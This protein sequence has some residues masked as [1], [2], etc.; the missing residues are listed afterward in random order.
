MQNLLAQEHPLSITTQ[1]AVRRVGAIV[2]MLADDI[3]HAISIAETMEAANRIVPP[4]LAGRDIEGADAYRVI[5]HSLAQKLALDVARIFDASGGRELDIQDKASIPVLIHH[6]R[7]PEVTTSLIAKTEFW[8]PL[9]RRITLA[10]AEACQGAI[11]LAIQRAAV[12]ATGETAEALTRVR[13]LRTRRLAHLLFDKEPD[14]LPRYAD[15][16]ALLKTAQHIGT[17]AVL[18]VQGKVTVF[19]ENRRISRD[20]AERFWEQVLKG[21]LATNSDGQ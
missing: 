20:D 15:L 17:A 4:G 19:K 6:L 9:P 3:R 21:I 14:P 10:P 5:E 7:K 18:A 11:A 1:E 12:L 2:P 13:Q 8:A 16:F